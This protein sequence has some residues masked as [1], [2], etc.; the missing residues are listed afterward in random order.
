MKSTSFKLGRYLRFTLL[1]LMLAAQGIVNAH[2]LGA[3]HSLK[4]DVCTTCLIGHGLGGA[5]NVS[6]AAPP[7]QVWQVL[8]P[9]HSITDTLVSPTYST[10][11][12]APP[13]SL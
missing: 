10:F 9:I 11:A 1:L 4:S 2:E 12:R 13:A 7:L 5:V 6:H 8:I 3:S